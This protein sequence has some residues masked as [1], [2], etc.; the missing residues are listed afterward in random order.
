MK[1]LVINRIK[2]DL[3][4][5]LDVI[6]DIVTSIFT[7][8]VSFFFWNTLLDNFEIFGMKKSD[9][10]LFLFYQKLTFFFVR[11][12]Y[13]MF[14]STTRQFIRGDVVQKMVY[15]LGVYRYNFFKNVE[16]PYHYFVEMGTY[17]YL[18]ISFGAKINLNFFFGIL[19][20]LFFSI[21]II[22][23]FYFVHSLSLLY[24]LRTVL[25]A[26]KDFL[27]ISSRYPSFIYKG[28]LFLAMNI[29]LPAFAYGS[30]Q[31]IYYKLGNLGIYYLSFLFSILF[32]FFGYL[33][34]GKAWR[35]Y[36]AYGA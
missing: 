2:T 18:A 36:E 11:Y 10:F 28:W 25:S 26:S 1:R 35:E 4:F 5:P 23:F 27:Y 20:C 3:E 21:P 29:F 16:I 14:R 31:L 13:K 15:P 17:L 6:Q 24:Q 12:F 34:N 19:L 22:S 9:A 32:F 30:A 33:I 7:A 8:L